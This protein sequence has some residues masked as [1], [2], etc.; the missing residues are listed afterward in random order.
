MNDYY[1]YY[2]SHGICVTCGQE[3]AAPGRVRCWMCLASQREHE[4]IYRERTAQSEREKWNA[5]RREEASTLRQKRRENGLCPNCGKDRIDK[6]YVLCEKCRRSAKRYAEKKRRDLG[7]VS[8]GLRGDGMFCAVCL[9]PVE[10]D[11]N[12][13]CDR[14]YANNLVSIRKAR[15]SQDNLNH[16]WRKIQYG[17]RSRAN[18]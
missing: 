5:I 18:P 3:N 4:A 2:K 16:P 10:Q 11:G 15:E 8:Q 12:K 14:C 9:K 13:L 17:R 1:H 6:A 7:V